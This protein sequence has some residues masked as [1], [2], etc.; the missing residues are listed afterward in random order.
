MWSRV[1]IYGLFFLFVYYFVGHKEAVDLKKFNESLSFLPRD[2]FIT[3]FSIAFFG[4]YHRGSGKFVKICIYPLCFLV[5]F[6]ISDVAFTLDNVFNSFF[7][8]FNTRSLRRIGLC[9]L[10][11]V[12]LY[13]DWFRVSARYSFLCNMYGVLAKDLYENACLG[14]FLFEENYQML[15]QQNLLISLD[16][17]GDIVCFSPL[18]NSPKS[19]PHGET[20]P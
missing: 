3:F 8:L 15:K 13:Q 6:Y 4:L 2:I 12:G 18:G 20:M 11:N 1:V 5:N 9:L 10:F 14:R 19:G 16:Q 7:I 17:P